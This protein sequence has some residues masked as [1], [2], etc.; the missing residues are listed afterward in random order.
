MLYQQFILLHGA[1]RDAKNYK[2]IICNN[3]EAFQKARRFAYVY[4]HYSKPKHEL[5]LHA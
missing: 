4:E 5:L 3:N 2:T 1:G